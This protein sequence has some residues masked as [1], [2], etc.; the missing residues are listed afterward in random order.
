MFLTKKALD[1]RNFLRAAGAV[2]ALPMLDAMTPAFAATTKAVPRISFLYIPNGVSPRK[3]TPTGTGKDFKFSPTLSPLEPFKDQVNV[4]SNLA[5]HCADRQNDGAGDHSRATGAFLSGTHAKRTQGADLHCGVTADQIAAKTLGK[6]NLLASLELSLEDRNV[7]PL[8]DEG[9][10]CAYSNTLSWTSPTTPIPMEND[11]RLVFE[12]LFGEEGNAKERAARLAEDRSI[13]DSVTGT[14]GRLKAELGAGDKRKLDQYFTSVREVEQRLQRIEAKNAQTPEAAMSMGRPL[15]VPEKF[16][17]HIRLMFDLKV[18]AFQA[19]ITRVTTLMLGREMA[20]RS[21]PQI[22]VPDSH[23]SLSHH[24]NN[25]EKL[26]K[27]GK[28]DNYHVQQVAYFLGKLRDAKDGENSLLDN[29][30]VMYGG[31]IANGNL[32]NH[33]NLPIFLVGGGA[34]QLQGG[35]HIEFKEDTPMSNLLR[36]ILHKTGVETESLG[37]S[38]GLLTEL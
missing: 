36:T 22:G 11:P 29:S 33:V 14:I 8:C 27:L 21:Y 6:D 23:H 4:L 38:T 5:H 24:D 19:D 1:R 15:G 31:A 3:W 26:N 28:I 9:Y 37:D 35:R 18:L 32:H 17:D 34:G 30:I 16:E 13:L 20:V 12:R 2:I 10:T 7:A 25:P